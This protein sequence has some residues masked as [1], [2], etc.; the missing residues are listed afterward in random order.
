MGELECSW[1]MPI[2]LN[3][4]SIHAEINSKWL[5]VTT[6]IS[7]LHYINT[8]LYRFDVSNDFVKVGDEIR[9]G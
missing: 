2:S 8:W 4:A 5:V 7:D 6:T 9:I 3:P 1:A